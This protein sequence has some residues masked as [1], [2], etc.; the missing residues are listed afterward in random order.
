MQAFA[1]PAVE[2]AAL[3]IAVTEAWVLIAVLT[4]VGVLV[5]L[6]VKSN[7]PERLCRPHD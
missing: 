4:A 1:R 2:R 7:L 3:T 6:A 5:A